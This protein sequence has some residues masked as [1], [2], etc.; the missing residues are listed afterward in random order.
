MG[1]GLRCA[2]PALPPIA[3]RPE[4]PN[5]SQFSFRQRVAQYLFDAGVVA[6]AAGADCAGDIGRQPE[7]DMDFRVL[8]PAAGP[9]VSIPY[10]GPE[11]PP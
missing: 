9:S 8:Q 10:T 4:N 5:G 6:A 1:G 2:L 11:R 7:A 3:A